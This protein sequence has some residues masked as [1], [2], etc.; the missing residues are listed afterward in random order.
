MVFKAITDK[1]GKITIPFAEREAEGL[2]PN[3]VVQ[4]KLKIIGKRVNGVT[5]I[6]RKMNETI[7]RKMNEN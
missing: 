5:T 4:V 1:S 6:F 3:T 7:F 2:G